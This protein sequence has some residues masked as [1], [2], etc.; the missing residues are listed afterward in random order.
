MG[1][2]G[3]LSLSEIERIEAELQAQVQL[4]RKSYE[5]AKEE[6]RRLLGISHDIGMGHPDGTSAIARA[7]EV[8][9]VAT[10]GYTLALKNLSEFVLERKFP[11]PSGLN[12]L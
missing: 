6:A 2:T 12:K 4:A 7:C 1:G 3:D 5:V 9:R 8:Q 11:A 10:R